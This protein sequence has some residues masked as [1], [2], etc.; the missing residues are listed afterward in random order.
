MKK[1]I[2]VLLLFGFLSGINFGQHKVDF[3]FKLRYKQ[4]LQPI[5]YVWL[6]VTADSGS[7]NEGQPYVVHPFTLPSALSKLQ[8]VYDAVVGSVFKLESGALNNDLFLEIMLDSL[9]LS[10]GTYV[11]VFQDT[12]FVLLNIKV[13]VNGQPYSGNY[14]LNSN[15]YLTFSI[16]KT[17]KFLSFLNSL[18]MTPDDLGFAYVG[19]NGWDPVG[20]FTENTADTIKFKAVHMSKFGGGRGHISS[21]TGVGLENLKGIPTKFALEQNYPNPF[22][23]TTKIR[24]SIPETGFVSLKVF[25]ILGSQVA[26]LISQ[27]QKAGNYEVEFNAQ[28][29][30][31]GIYFY[32][33][34]SNNVVLTKKM[35]LVK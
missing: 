12:L 33:L 30:P 7:F 26:T 16:P 20:I 9:D 5:G 28:N 2:Y 4:P 11:P 14:L 17:Q 25:N 23:P 31:S 10:T 34:E 29:L 8:P 32:T 27:N 15:K 22:N 19:K 3:V 1:Y 35:L 13:F 6:T 21:T 24:Y 18:G